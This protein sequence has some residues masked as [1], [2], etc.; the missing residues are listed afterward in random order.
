MSGAAV[1]ITPVPDDAARL[2][3]L[4]SRC[5]TDTF[6]HLYHS[7]DLAAFLGGQ[8]ERRWRA[9]LAD[10]AFAIRAVP[11]DGELVGFAKLGPVSLPVKPAG[12]AI[13]LRQFYLLA[14]QQGTGL[15]QRLM[16]WVIDEA[17]ARGMEEVFL[18]VFIDNPRAR[19]F[20]ERFGFER[21]GAYAFMVG[22]HA[23]EDDLM[24]LTL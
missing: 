22:S 9:E 23:D 19:R 21:V 13:E 14:G 15:A 4:F 20:Y 10:P 3:T 12:A 1:I 7:D 16:A 18:S 17:R 2:L 11:V 24:R 6:G 5:F 8:S